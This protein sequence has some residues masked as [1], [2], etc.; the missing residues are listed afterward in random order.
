MERQWP[1]DDNGMQRTKDEYSN[2]DIV[3]RNLT[4]GSGRE[5]FL[6]QA[7]FSDWGSWPANLEP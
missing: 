2:H 7:P 1:Q 4:L 3:C 6:V 5:L